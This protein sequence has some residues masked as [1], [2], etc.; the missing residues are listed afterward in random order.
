MTPKQ[1]CPV[2]WFYIDAPRG[3]QCVKKA[4]HSGSHA[5]ACD[6]PGKFY[7]GLSATR[8]TEDSKHLE[9]K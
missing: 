9:E 5:C 2:Q 6:G 7:N 1:L 8:E 4:G 3:H